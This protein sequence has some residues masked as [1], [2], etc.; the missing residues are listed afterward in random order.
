MSGSTSTRHWN[1][2]P[3]KT[4]RGGEMAT[5]AHG[6]IP[7]ISESLLTQLRQSKKKKKERNNASCKDSTLGVNSK[8]FVAAT[9]IVLCSSSFFT[10]GNG[11]ICHVLPFS[12]ALTAYFSF[13]FLRASCGLCMHSSYLLLLL[14]V[15]SST[16]WL[17]LHCVMHGSFCSEID[18]WMQ[19]IELQLQASRV[20][21]EFCLE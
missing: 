7:F 1:N 19:C 2:E 17:A 12:I 13:L 9:T 6:E 8:S 16:F 18:T 3:N 10:D 4:K 15:P 21:H 14:L 5:Q 11:W 20:E